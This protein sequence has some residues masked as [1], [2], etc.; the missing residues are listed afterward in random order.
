MNPDGRDEEEQI[1]E[2]PH[3]VLVQLPVGGVARLRFRRR[4]P[5]Q[6]HQV[7][8]PKTVVS[9]LAYVLGKLRPPKLTRYNFVWSPDMGDILP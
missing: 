4:R 7:E 2:A 3:R 5:E 6:R 1:D 8:K 9:V